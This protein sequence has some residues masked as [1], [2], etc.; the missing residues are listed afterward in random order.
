MLQLKPNGTKAPELDL[1]YS[2]GDTP[3]LK[4]QKDKMVLLNF[5]ATGLP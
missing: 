2:N 5:T 3:L 1:K 4:N